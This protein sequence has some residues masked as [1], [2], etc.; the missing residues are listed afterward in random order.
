LIQIKQ[1]KHFIQNWKTNKEGIV[2]E[3]IIAIS[4]IVMSSIIWLVGQLIVSKT[5]DAFMPWF[6]ITDPRVLITANAAMTGYSI[7]IIIVDILFL[8]WWGLST[9]KHE[10][11]EEP[12]GR[13]N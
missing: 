1:V 4:F 8:V 3:G 9:Q 2:K 11:F 13:F 6:A 12:M 7:S 5:F 10:S